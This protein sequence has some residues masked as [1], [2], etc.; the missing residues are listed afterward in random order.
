[1]PQ[2]QDECTGWKQS[3]GLV[4]EIWNWLPLLVVL[5]SMHLRKQ[6]GEEGSGGKGEDSQRKEDGCSQQ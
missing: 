2:G 4:S 6:S 3:W 5:I 1:M